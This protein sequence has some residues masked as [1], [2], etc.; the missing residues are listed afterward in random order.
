[1]PAIVGSL[2][3][4]YTDEARQNNVEG[5]I[6]L[7]VIFCANGRISDITVEGGLPFGLTERAKETMRKIRF[8]PALKDS[9][10]VTVITKQV[11]TCKENMCTA[12]TM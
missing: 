1:M 6:I 12:T 5:K 2:E 9:Q 10:P 7:Q 8:A 11:F 4:A 3:F